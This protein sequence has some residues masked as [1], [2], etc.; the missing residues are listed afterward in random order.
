VL[1]VVNVGLQFDLLRLSEV[2]RDGLEGS[3][4]GFLGHSMIY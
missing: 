4:D 3:I 2:V 1:I